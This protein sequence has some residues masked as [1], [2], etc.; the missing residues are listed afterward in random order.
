MFY[1]DESDVEISGLG[2]CSFNDSTGIFKVEKIVLCHQENAATTTDLDPK[3]VAK[4]MYELR[5]EPSQLKFW[6]H[7]HVNMGVFWS[8]TDSATMLELAEHGWFMSTVFNKKRELLSCLTFPT[9]FGPFEV[10]QMETEITEKAP[11]IEPPEHAVW[12]ASMK[13]RCKEKS[14]FPASARV[15]DG[16]KRGRKSY[17]AH[18]HGR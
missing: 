2:T 16:T 9:E 5:N 3:S 1:V 15:Y 7:S 12:R 18:N 10:N 8:G 11:V 6:W 13:E 4:A 14:S 17:G